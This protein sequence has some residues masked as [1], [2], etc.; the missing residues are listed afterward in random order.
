VTRWDGAQPAADTLAAHSKTYN[1]LDHK[2]RVGIVFYGIIHIFPKRETEMEQRGRPKDLANRQGNKG[3]KFPRIVV[4]FKVTLAF[5]TGETEG[6]GTLINLS[7][8]GCAIKS[9]TRVENGAILDLSLQ[10]SGSDQ[11]V[12]IEVAVV[13]WTELGAFGV[14]FYTMKMEQ[15][16]QTKL[17]LLLEEVES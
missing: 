5:K 8:G 16:E 4:K 10:L 15:E 12:R 11:T 3:R 14:E 9:T 6:A 2:G 13:R 1:S 17:G 7:M